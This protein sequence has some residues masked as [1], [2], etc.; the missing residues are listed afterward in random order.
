MLSDADLHGV[1][2]HSEAEKQPLDVDRFFSCFPRE[3]SQPG[4]LEGTLVR[5]KDGR[6]LFTAHRVDPTEDVEMGGA[7]Y[8]MMQESRDVGRSWSEPWEMKDEKGKRIWAL[9]HTEL[10]LPSGEL[11]LI[12]SEMWHPYGHRGRDAGR[13]M[14]FRT[15]RDEGRTW[16]APTVMAQSFCMTCT[17]HAIILSSGRILAPTFT[18]MSPLSGTEAEAWATGGPE[19][20]PSF[21]Y[22]SALFSDDNGRSWQKSMSELFISRYRQNFDLEEPTVIELNN[23]T[24]LMHLRNPMGRMSRSYSTDQGLTWSVPE[25]I[26]IAA[27]NCPSM[28]KR[29]PATGAL[30]MVWNQASMQE[31]VNGLHRARLSCAIS[32]DE[33]KSWEDFK[34]LE[35][36]DDS[37]AVNPPPPSWFRIVEQFEDYG[38]Q[39]PG[40]TSRYHRAPGPLRICYPHVMFDGDE[41]LIVYDFG[42]GSL[43]NASGIKLRAI[44]IDWFVS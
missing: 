30:L 18:W 20:T 34:N 9:H 8:L 33:G 11:G 35:S 5:G 29:I 44:P 32:T 38:Y 12:C 36:L 23:D 22:S 28:I 42:H 26:H 16:S 37:T 2:G 7:P 17:G 15:S 19:G 39:Q 21:S 13:S 25:D 31:I 41:A 6:I 1:P 40:N 4:S 3:P 24:L 43:G 27:A 10:R 14:M